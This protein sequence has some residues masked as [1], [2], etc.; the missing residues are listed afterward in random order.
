MRSEKYEN[1]TTKNQ[2][3]RYTIIAVC[4]ALLVLA[5]AV[6]TVRANPQWI[7]KWDDRTLNIENEKDGAAAN[8]PTNP[9]QVQDVTK[10]VPTVDSKNNP[11]SQGSSEAKPQA[12][13]PQTVM[14]QPA[15]GTVSKKFSPEA[16]VYSKT[17]DQYTVHNGIDIDGEISDQVCAA[18]EGTVTKVYSDDSLGLTIEITHGDGLI[19]KYCGLSTDKMVG[20]GDVVK[21]GQVIS[22]IGDSTLFESADPLHLHFEVWKDGTAVDPEKYFKKK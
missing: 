17:L 10:P 12:Q 9:V 20:E 22:G 15:K 7:S 18:A 2:S 8:L 14:V 6:Y 11:K 13:S 5:G 16:P 4:C 19:S 21:Q 3:F 1:E